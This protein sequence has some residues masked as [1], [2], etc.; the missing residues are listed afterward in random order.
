MKVVRPAIALSE[1]PYFQSTSLGSYS[2]SGR[3]KEG[4][5][6]PQTAEPA[7]HVTQ[8]SLAHLTCIF[9]IYSL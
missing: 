3:E 1:V 4:K 2:T 9:V 5:V 7:L 8:S 6:E